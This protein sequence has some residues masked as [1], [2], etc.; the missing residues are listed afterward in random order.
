MATA[1]GPL[2]TAM[3]GPKVRGATAKAVTVPAMRAL[4]TQAVLPSGVMAMALSAEFTG[5]GT[6]VPAVPV[7]MSIGVSS[8]WLATFWA[9]VTHAVLPSGVMAMAVGS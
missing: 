2:P 5:N 8:V 1:L 4:V 9:S 7:A 6:G 3:E